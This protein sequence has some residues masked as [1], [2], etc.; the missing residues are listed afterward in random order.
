MLFL[1]FGLLSFKL[2]LPLLLLELDLHSFLRLL[3]L[4]LS[5]LGG[6]ILECG[7]GQVEHL[8]FAVVHQLYDH[9]LPR[10]ESSEN[11]LPDSEVPLGCV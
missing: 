2:D 1:H 10:L 4:L 7:L 3:F 9:L 8:S 5:L 11:E 6:V